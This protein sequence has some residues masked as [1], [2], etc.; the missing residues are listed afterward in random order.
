MIMSILQHRRNIQNYDSFRFIFKNVHLLSMKLIYVLHV[1]FSVMHNFSP[2]VRTKIPKFIMP[3]VDVV[4]VLFYMHTVSSIQNK[5]CTINVLVSSCFY[6]P[7]LWSKI[8]GYRNH[9]WYKLVTEC[10]IS[11]IYIHRSSYS[12]QNLYNYTHQVQ[13]ENTQMVSKCTMRLK[14]VMA[15]QS[16]HWNSFLL[17]LAVT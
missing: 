12:A 10:N 2:D 7:H 9:A 17:Q 8:L 11:R 4:I 15:Q 1:C 13:Y 6:I 16:F 14:I 3:L 5:L